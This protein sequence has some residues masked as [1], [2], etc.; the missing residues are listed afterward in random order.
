MVD[1][2]EENKLAV[3]KRDSNAL[4]VNAEAG[5]LDVVQ[6]INDLTLLTA[7]DAKK[8]VDAQPFILSTYTDVP[9]Y[10]PLVIK[11]SSVLNDKSFPTADTK[12]WQCKKE[13]EVHFTQL[14]SEIYKYERCMVDIEEMDYIIASSEHQI[15]SIS[16]ESVKDSLDPIKLGF[17]LKR[18]KIKRQEYLFNMKLL[19]KSIKY[20]IQEIVDWA[21]ISKKMMEPNCKYDTKNYNAHLT[22][23]LYKT[24]Q[25]C[26]NKAAG[27]DKAK[28][29]AQL[30]TLRRLIKEMS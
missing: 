28:Y 30:S 11:L 2:T 22:E 8:L 10:R 1:N 9:E 20:R 17:E 27:E 3:I 14:V 12:Y 7:S 6:K 21:A 5:A 19:E 13:A 25:E 15:A 23:G 29:E 24:L 18:V 26:I 4:M 16:L